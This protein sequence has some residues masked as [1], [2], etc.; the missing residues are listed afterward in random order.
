MAKKDKNDR[1]IGEKNKKMLC[2]FVFCEIFSAI[3]R[4]RKTLPSDKDME[5]NDL[6]AIN[7]LTIRRETNSGGHCN[8]GGGLFLPL[9]LRE[10]L[11][12]GEL[13]MSDGTEE[14]PSNFEGSSIKGIHKDART[15]LTC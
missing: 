5:T 6:K 1:G 15:S 3:S 11:N 12:Q 10:I 9:H 4:C 2:S 13:S 7:L 8:E 14:E